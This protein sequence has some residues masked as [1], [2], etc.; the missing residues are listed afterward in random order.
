VA[1]W[2][3]HPDQ[4]N[5]LAFAPDSRTLATASHDR[6]VRLWDTVSGEERLTLRG[7]TA[8]VSAVA[9]SR[10]GRALASGSYDKTVRVWDLPPIPGHSPKP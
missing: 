5:A 7:H 6:T 10:D 3:G 8:A 2:Q 4:I 1:T 9:F